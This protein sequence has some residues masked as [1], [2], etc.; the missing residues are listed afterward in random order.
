MIGRDC[1]DI[2]FKYVHNLHM[3]DVV[4]EIREKT[5]LSSSFYDGVDY[6]Q[7]ML[8]NDIILKVV[9]VGFILLS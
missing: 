3:V 9:L 2:I 6:C 5:N 8:F 1:E 4:E 7:F